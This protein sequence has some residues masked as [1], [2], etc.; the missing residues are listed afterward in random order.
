MLDVRRLQLL[1]AVISSG[2][3]SAAAANLG[4]TPSAVSQQVAT[5]ERQTGVQL[6]ERLG[7]G[8]RPTEAG[9]LLAE[10][11]AIIDR[12]VADAERAL[13]DLRSG[14][15]GR[16]RV[17]YFATAGAAL[18]PPALARLRAEHP[19]VHVELDLLDP[20]DPLRAVASG[21]ADLAIVVAADPAPP[22]I[23]LVR[24][25]E[26]PFLVALPAA[27]PLAGEE[28]VELGGLAGEPWVGNEWPTGQCSEIVREAC[29]AA[30]FTPDV[31]VQ[32]DD[33]ATAQ[34]FVAAGLGV[35][36]IPRLGLGAPRPDV[37]VRPLHNPAPSRVVHA[38]LREG[39]LSHPALK[40]LVEGL[41]DAASG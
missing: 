28:V 12:H 14:V 6:L 39:A 11:A 33:Y 20:G 19:H 37:A 41:V 21:D 17:R 8:I 26:E 29:A 27:H 3:V 35:S 4:Y 36:V 32:A 2:S 9:T 31:V 34:G 7:R 16:V 5:L 1:R 18:I 22:G 24:L 23:R 40:S 38:A 10:H 25:L 30:G 15:T 13:A